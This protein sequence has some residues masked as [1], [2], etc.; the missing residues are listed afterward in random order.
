MWGILERIRVVRAAALVMRDEHS[1]GALRTKALRSRER[2]ST[3]SCS[4]RPRFRGKQ[5]CKP[6]SRGTGALVPTPRPPLLLLRLLLL[7]PSNPA[8]VRAR[9][10]APPSPHPSFH[11]GSLRLAGVRRALLCAGPWRGHPA[12]SPRPRGSRTL[13]PPSLPP[14]PGGCGRGGGLDF[15]AERSRKPKP[16]IRARGAA[17]GSPTW[18]AR[19]RASPRPRG[20]PRLALR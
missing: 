20:V 10:A 12:P 2:G 19:E 13:P 9:T 3:P 11:P 6:T 1:H 18:A 4:R 15:I 8:C 16:R 7:Q 5:R 14:A 17:G